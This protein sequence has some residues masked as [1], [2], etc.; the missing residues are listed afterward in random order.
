MV[1]ADDSLSDCAASGHNE[2]LQSVLINV[3]QNKDPFRKK[4]NNHLCIL[5]YF[6]TTKAKEH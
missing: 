3:D 2:I 1:H 6:F 5:E 4:R